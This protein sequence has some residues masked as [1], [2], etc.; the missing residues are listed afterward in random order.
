MTN[1]TTHTVVEILGKSYPIKCPEAELESLQL[2]VQML[3]KKMAH[4]QGANKNM[5]QEGA[6]V[7]AALNM[8]H[9]FLQ[10]D[11]QKNGFM[12]RIHQRIAQLL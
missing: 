4:I 8:A 2:A 9:D 10:L 6:A 5:S 7:I 11:E 1:K 3:N 12:D